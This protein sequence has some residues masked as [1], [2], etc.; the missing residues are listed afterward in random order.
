MGMMMNMRQRKHAFNRDHVV[1]TFHVTSDM[2]LPQDHEQ[3]AAYIAHALNRFLTRCLKGRK[4]RHSLFYLALH[5]ENGS[6]I[7]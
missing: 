1:L 6:E 5:L 7:A 3:R 4:R 2:N